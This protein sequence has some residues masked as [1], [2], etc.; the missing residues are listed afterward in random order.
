MPKLTE[1][2]WRKAEKNMAM[3]ER[4]RLLKV[5]V[6]KTTSNPNVLVKRDGVWKLPQIGE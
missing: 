1:S 2:I 6:V 3:R 4:R 5:G